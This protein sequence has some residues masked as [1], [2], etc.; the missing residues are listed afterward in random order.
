M[1][2]YAFRTRERLPGL[3]PLAGCPRCDGP[4]LIDRQDCRETFCLDCG[5]RTYPPFDT[6]TPKY[7]R[8]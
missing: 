4:W 3:V 8:N 2:N 1:V 7:L 5:Y 6:R